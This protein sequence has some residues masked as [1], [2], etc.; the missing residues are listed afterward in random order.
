[1]SM[2]FYMG[3]DVTDCDDGISEHILIAFFSNP[4]KEQVWILLKKIENITKYSKY[5]LKCLTTV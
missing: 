3:D 4:G 2:R 5:G 1:M